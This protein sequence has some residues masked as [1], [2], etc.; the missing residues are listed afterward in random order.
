MKSLGVILLGEMW[1]LA[2]NGSVKGVENPEFRG[3]VEFEDVKG[4]FQTR[5]QRGL[6]AHMCSCFHTSWKMHA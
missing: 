2:L 1:L 3:Q 6:G 4:A 5:E